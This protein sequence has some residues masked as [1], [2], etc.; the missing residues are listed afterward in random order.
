MWLLLA[1]CS[2]VSASKP[3]GAEELEVAVLMHRFQV[4]SEKLY[5]AGK[6]ENWELASF[7]L[8]ELEEGA[9][10]L[11]DANVSEEGFSLSKGVEAIFVPAHHKLEEVVKA[12]SSAEFEGAYAGLVGSCNACHGASKHGFIVI[13]TPTRPAFSGQKYTP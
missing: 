12:K 11:R 7:Y 13:Q 8:H 1:A 2:T 5:F 6:A 9:A 10:E 4:H 3:D